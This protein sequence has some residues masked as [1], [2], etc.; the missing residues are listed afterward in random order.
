[1]IVTMT[2]MVV[3]SM[4]QLFHTGTDLYADLVPSLLD[5]DAHA[6]LG[7]PDPVV[8]AAM[9]ATRDADDPREAYLDAVV[10]LCTAR[11]FMPVMGEGRELGA[12]K[13]TNAQGRTAL[14]AFTGIDSLTAWDARARPV[15]GH[16]DDLAATVTEAGADVLLLDVAGPTPVVLGP[17][18]LGPLEE[19]RRL[20][21]TGDGFAW[22]SLVE[23][24]GPSAAT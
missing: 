24:P 23:A 2:T 21:R 9:A 11:F 1:M 22:L 4:G 7:A 17:E 16:L 8:R 15:P 12:V 19:G 6:D 10:A 3:S 13:L 14:L 20:V 5:P 18:L